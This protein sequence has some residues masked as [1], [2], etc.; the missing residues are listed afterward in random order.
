MTLAWLRRVAALKI[1]TAL[2]GNDDL[3]ARG[4]WGRRPGGFP[5]TANVAPKLMAPVEAARWRRHRH[6]PCDQQPPPPLL[7]ELFLR[8]GTRFR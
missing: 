7:H 4:A 5:V 1:S 8:I 3:L 2:P 6:G